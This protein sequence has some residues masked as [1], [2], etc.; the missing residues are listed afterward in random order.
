MA[1]SRVASRRLRSACRK[2][3]R[4]VRKCR[5]GG[6]AVRASPAAAR[7]AT[8]QRVERSPRETSL[9][10]LRHSNDREP[11]ISRERAGGKFRYRN[12][13]GRLIGDRRLLK[14]I[15]ALAVRSEE[16]T[17]ALQSLMRS[18]YAVFCLKK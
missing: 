8:E 2:H 12:A 14:R 15:A 17:S 5:L 1:R 6:G 18:P 7:A 4:R 10:R 9:T 16:H 11:G 3:A 13:K